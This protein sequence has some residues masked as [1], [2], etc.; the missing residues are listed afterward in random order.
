MT[1]PVLIKFRVPSTVLV[2]L[3]LGY[4]CAASG[5]IVHSLG[6][7]LVGVAILVWPAIQ[8]WR[9]GQATRRWKYRLLV[10][11]A[12][13]H[14]RKG[15]L[16]NLEPVEL[17]WHEIGGVVLLEPVATNK[18]LDVVVFLPPFAVSPGA[19]GEA[20]AAF[21]ERVGSRDPEAL[22]RIWFSLRLHHR[23]VT[24]V[25]DYVRTNHPRVVVK[26]VTST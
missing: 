4:G 15:P 20:L 25:L 10:D 2:V 11:D 21:Q 19:L 18:R 3:V 6:L 9:G 5:V 13:V 26:E 16:R 14:L 1:S 12:G 17:G 8:L 24:R 7:V 22:G 23:E